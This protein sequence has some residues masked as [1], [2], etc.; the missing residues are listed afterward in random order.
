MGYKKCE[1]AAVSA[2]R[3]GLEY[4]PDM[5]EAR[6]ELED[7]VMSLFVRG[8]WLTKE[9]EEIPITEMTEQHIQNTINMIQKNKDDFRRIYIP[10]FRKELKKRAK[11]REVKADE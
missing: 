8:V 9:D 6:T 11:L 10:V 5:F 3:S 2:A 4:S 1:S 7:Q